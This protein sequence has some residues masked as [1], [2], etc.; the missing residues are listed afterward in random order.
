MF[1]CFIQ[2]SLLN[3]DRINISYENWHFYGKNFALLVLSFCGPRGAATEAA[4]K[5]RGERIAA[6]EVEYS[7]R[8]P[9]LAST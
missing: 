5:D 2:R 7:I 1:T 6:T 3:S 9:G 4:E 8:S